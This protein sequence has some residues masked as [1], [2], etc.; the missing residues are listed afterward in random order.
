MS[1]LKRTMLAFALILAVGTIQGLITATNFSSLASRI[2]DATVKPVVAVDAARASWIHFRRAQ[3]FVANATEGIRFERSEQTLSAFRQIITKTD[4]E[5]LRLKG[6]LVSEAAAKSHGEVE[7]LIAQWNARA[8]VLIG[9]QPATAIPAPYTMTKLEETIRARLDSLVAVAIS[10]AERTRTDISSAAVTFS[11]VTWG[12]LV[13]SLMAG[14]ALATALGVSMTRPLS[15]LEAAMA[16]LAEGSTDIAVPEAERRDE[17]GSMARAVQV[18]KVNTQTRDLLQSEAAEQRRKAETA[19]QLAEDERNKSAALQEKVSKEQSELIHQ[20]GE[21]LGKLAR[22]DVTVRLV[23]HTDDVFRQIKDDF[24]RMGDAVQAIADRIGTATQTVG[25]TTREISV[26]VHDLSGRTEQQA[27]ALEQ[28]ATSLEELTAT[29]RNNAGYAETANKAAHAAS[30]LAA[31]GSQV[32]GRA[33]GAMTK[34]EESSRQISEMV[35]LIEEIAFQT[36]I[37]ALNAAVESAHAGDAGR[38]FAVV[39]SEVRALSQH[40]SQTLKE[41]KALISS[42]E[43]NV[44]AGAQLVKQAGDSLTSIVNSAKQVADII[45]EIA[46]ASREQAS[47]IDVVSRAVNDM[48]QLTQ[49]NAALVEETNNTLTSA[50]IQVDELRHAVAFFKAGNKF[51]ANEAHPIQ[52]VPARTAAGTRS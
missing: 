39:A 5:L 48:D 6:A 34:I 42:S 17:I 11:R 50:Q 9:V 19:R 27:S 46:S 7:A 10:D 35:A 22:G 44:K 13:L 3:Q 21:G 36:N 40:S 15:R 51:I 43:A 29:V 33:I 49:K 32:A 45:S 41:I 30:E 28:T 2:N 14:F 38:G 26:G 47:S 31:E 37:L 8:L 16:K 23:A 18:F 20:L 52:D 1:I 24:N 4:A 25:T 12:L